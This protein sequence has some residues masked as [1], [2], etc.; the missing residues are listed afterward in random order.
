MANDNKTVKQI[1]KEMQKDLALL[2]FAN[3]TRKANGDY[4]DVSCIET[5]KFAKRILAAHK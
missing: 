3:G 5:K 4:S 1:A 2:Y